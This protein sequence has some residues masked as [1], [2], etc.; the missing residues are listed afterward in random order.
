[1]SDEGRDIVNF[2]CIAI[3]EPIPDIGWYFNGAVINISDN[4]TKYMI[5]SQP[6]NMT[7]TEETLTIYNATNADVGVYTCIASNIIGNDTSHGE[8]MCYVI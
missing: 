2:T 6:I 5:M 8:T 3:G 1:M 7:V 4:S